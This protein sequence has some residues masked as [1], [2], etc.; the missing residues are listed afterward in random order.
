M[1][2]VSIIVMP[3]AISWRTSRNFTGWHI[4]RADADSSTECAINIAQL[5]PQM[6]T[7]APLDRVSGHICLHCCRQALA[8]AS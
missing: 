8:R 5:R 6:V 2:R 7:T 4:E 1:A 3:R